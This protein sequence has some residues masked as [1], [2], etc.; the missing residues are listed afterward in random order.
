MNTTMS[1]YREIPL[2][3]MGYME[4]KS[5]LSGE[6][7]RTLLPNHTAS[8]SSFG[9]PSMD[10]YA[11]NSSIWRPQMTNLGLS[12]QFPGAPQFFSLNG[13]FFANNPTFE[14]C[15]GDKVIWY[16]NAFGGASHVFHMH[17]H[18]VVEQGQK[19]FAASLNDG[20]GHTLYMNA[21]SRGLW[22]VVCHVNNHHRMGMVGNYRVYGEGEC[23][24]PALGG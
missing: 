13:Y 1:T 17:G 19:A 16:V 18:S 4:S 3:Y 23:P 7:A 12:G 21:T 2:L 6:N 11:S 22:Q 5:F 24:L 9:M 20:N 14:M 10:L 8:M 15:L